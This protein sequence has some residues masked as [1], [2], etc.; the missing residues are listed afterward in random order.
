MKIELT[1]GYYVD[2]KSREFVLRQETIGHTREGAEELVDKVI[3]HFSN[4]HDTIE[5]FILLN[6]ITE[7]EKLTFEQYVT[8]VETLN[9]TAID[10]IENAAKQVLENKIE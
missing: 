1:S 8:A 7:D 9:Q 2:I 3:G 6:Q 10:A 5:R 4:L